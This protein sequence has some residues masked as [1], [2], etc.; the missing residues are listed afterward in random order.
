MH[1]EN[2][3]NIEM[4]KLIKIIL[5]IILIMAT[6]SIYMFYTRFVE[7][8]VDISNLADKELEMKREIKVQTSTVQTLSEALLIQKEKTHK[9]E[10]EKELAVDSL[11]KYNHWQK[12]RITRQYEK[13]IDSLNKLVNVKPSNFLPERYNRNKELP[14]STPVDSP[15]N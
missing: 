13:K 1:S 15:G 12:I 6:V 3:N 9:V 4:I 8:K 10:I 11:V 5:P 2:K 7:V 14:N